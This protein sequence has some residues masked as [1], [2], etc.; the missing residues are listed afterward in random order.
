MVTHGAGYGTDYYAYALLLGDNISNDLSFQNWGF[1]DLG[2]GLYDSAGVWHYRL[3]YWSPDIDSAYLGVHFKGDDD[4]MHYGWIRCTMADSI[5][6]FII[7]D[8]AY[9]SKCETAILAGDTIG[10]TATVAIEDIN[11]LNAIV[12]SFNKSIFI[13]L[14]QSKNNVEIHIYDLS[15]KIVYSGKIIN[16]F[17]QIELN[18][19][20]GVYIVELIDGE[21][22]LIKKIFIN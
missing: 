22:K 3:G 6:R 21:N 1:Q 7:H 10:D 15:G 8:Y 2:S 16:Q 11:S 14:D 18:R 20:K 12:Y 9:E 17:A 13:N 4:C 5:N 19:T